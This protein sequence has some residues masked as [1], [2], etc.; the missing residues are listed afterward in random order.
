MESEQ[1]N[2]VDSIKDI[3]RNSM[4]VPELNKH[5]DQAGGHIGQ[6]IEEITIKMKTIV[7]KPLMIKIYFTELDCFSHKF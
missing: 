4:K 6:N 2:H 5:L 1:A 7:R 3:I